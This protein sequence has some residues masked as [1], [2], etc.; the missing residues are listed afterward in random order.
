MDTFDEILSLV[1][2]AKTELAQQSGLEKVAQAERIKSARYQLNA[3][4]AAAREQK[5]TEALRLFN[6][7][8][9]ILQQGHLLQSEWAEI[10]VAQAMCHARLGQKREMKRMW[11]LA[12]KLEPDNEKLKTIAKQ[13][14]MIK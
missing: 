1:H 13:L 14:G 6:S 9:T 8:Q 12:H 4:L 11:N 10:Y 3:A 7:L 2:Q 5:Y